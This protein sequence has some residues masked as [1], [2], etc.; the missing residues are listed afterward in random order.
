MRVD[1]VGADDFA[2]HIQNPPREGD[3]RPFLRPIH[4]QFLPRLKL[5]DG[6]LLVVAVGSNYALFF[7]MLRQGHDLSDDTLAS[8]LLANATTVASF[9]IL[10]LS[11]IPVLAAIGQVVAL[12]ALLALLLSACFAAAPPSLTE[13]RA[14]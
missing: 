10:A 13:N 11:G 12:G 6:L 8:L 1:R 3:V 4:I 5:R 2:L 7:D 14:P 9:G